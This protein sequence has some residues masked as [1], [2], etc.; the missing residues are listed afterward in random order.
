MFHNNLRSG[1]KNLG[2]TNKYKNFG[3]LIIKKVVN[4]I[5][6]GC[7]ILRLKCTKFCSWFLSVRGQSDEEAYPFVGYMEFDT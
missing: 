2:S 5:A 7:H 4:V 6:T 3:Q 1:D